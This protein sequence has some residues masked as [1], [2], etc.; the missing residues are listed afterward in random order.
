MNEKDISTKHGDKIFC[1]FD[2][3]V[4]QSKQD[5]IFQAYRKAKRKGI[6]LIM[7]V[8]SFELWY[9]LHY[10]KTTH[11]FSS[12]K[13]LENELKK[14]ITNYEKNK[15]VFPVIIDNINK[16]IAHSKFLKKHHH[17]ELENPILD[18]KLNP[19]TDVYKVI[20]YIN[21]LLEE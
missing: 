8:P 1:V 19:S 9:L 2:S 20:E 3:D 6:E 21:G 12:N 18:M 16:A 7:S 17:L 14:F 4:N 15:N 11:C 5:R 10:K 13:E